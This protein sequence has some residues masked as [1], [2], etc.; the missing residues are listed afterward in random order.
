MHIQGKGRKQRVLPLWKQTAADLRAW[1][2]IRGNAPVPELFL[3]ARRLSITRFGFEYVL[4]KH[5]QAAMKSCPSLQSKRIS[6]HVLRHSSAILVLQATGDIR[7]VS[8]WLGHASIQTTEIYL[9]V[10]PTEK[11][12]AIEKIVPPMLKRGQFRTPDKLIA[13]LHNNA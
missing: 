12:E 1:L 5:A 10:D 8:L 7:K 11:L 13:T 4:K 6:P 2:A 3:N 9:R